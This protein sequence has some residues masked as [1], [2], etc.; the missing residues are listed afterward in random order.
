MIPGGRSLQ[1]CTDTGTTQLAIDRISASY[2]HGLC[3][4]APLSA[5]APLSPYPSILLPTPTP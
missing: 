5:D 2:Y 4:V 1:R 3:F